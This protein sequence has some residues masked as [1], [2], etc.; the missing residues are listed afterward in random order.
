[1]G[2]ELIQFSNFFRASPCLIRPNPYPS[3]SPNPPTSLAMSSVLASGPSSTSAAPSAPQ[4]PGVNAEAGP[5]PPATAGAPPPPG[6]PAAAPPP[7]TVAAASDAEAAPAMTRAVA[8]EALF[9]DG[10]GN[11]PLAGVK[12]LEGADS[13]ELKLFVDA[14]GRKCVAASTMIG[15]KPPSTSPVVYM[16]VS[17]DLEAVAVEEEGAQMWKDG[18]LNDGEWTALKAKLLKGEAHGGDTV[19]KN[20]TEDDTTLQSSAFGGGGTMGVGMG[21]GGGACI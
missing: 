21:G 14:S 10:T 2:E 13:H 1:M 17:E 6:I 5:P 19:G 9:R 8:C 16:H 7:A 11:H 18:T 12:E 3:L 4:V 15:A 20:D